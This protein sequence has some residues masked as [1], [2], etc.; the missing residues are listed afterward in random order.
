MSSTKQQQ[1]VLKDLWTNSADYRRNYQTDVDVEAILRLLDLSTASGLVDIGCGNGVFSVAAAQRHPS[2]QVWAFD[3][4]ESAVSECRAQAG[5]LHHANLS[6]GT[7]WAD[8]IPLGDAIADRALFRAVLHHIAEPQLVYNEI[9]RLLKPAGLL[10]LQAPCNYWESSFTHILSE[11]MLLMDETHRRFFYQP[12]EIVAGLQKAGFS[13]GEPE[14]W[15]YSLPYLDDRQAQVI[16]DHQA[17]E[18]L[19]LCQIEA[20]KWAIEN[21]WVRVVATKKE[22]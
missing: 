16:R 7:A 15:M 17:Q 13:V 14:C 18:R 10:V 5:D 1:T 4:L 6:L 9:G 19:H 21:Y 12:T 8:S 11:V 22:A 2:C 20:G 3:A